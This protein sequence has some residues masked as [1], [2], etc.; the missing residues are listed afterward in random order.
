VKKHG[1]ISERVVVDCREP[2]WRQELHSRLYA[3][4][5][6]DLINFEYELHGQSCELIAQAFGP[7]FQLDRVPT[8][9]AAHFRRRIDLFTRP[10][11]RGQNSV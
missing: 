5:E 8:A 1:A 10:G 2:E 6:V 7:E 3:G 4:S 9:K 11:Q